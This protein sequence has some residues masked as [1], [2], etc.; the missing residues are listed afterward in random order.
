MRRPAARSIWPGAVVGRRDLDHVEAAEAHARQRADAAR[1]PRAAAGPRPPACPVAGRERRVDHVDVEAEER[2]RLADARRAR[3]ARSRPAP[4][5][6]SSSPPIDL[7]AHLARVAEVG[8]RVERPAHAGQ[9]R[10]LRARAAP[11]RPPAGTACR[12]SSARRS[13]GPRCRRARRAA[14]APSGPCRAA[15]AR[16]SPSTIEWSPPSTIGD[17]AGRDAAAPRP[18]GDLARGPLGVAG[19]DVEVA[20]G[21]RPTAPRTRRRRAP[22]GTGRSSDRRRRG[23]PPG[24]KRAPGPVAR[25]GVERDADDADVDAR[26]V[27]RRAG[28]GRTCGCPCSGAP[29]RRRAGRSAAA[30]RVT[31]PPRAPC[32]ACGRSRRA[33][34]PPCASDRLDVLERLRREPLARQHVRDARRVRGERLGRDPPDRLARPAR[35]PGRRGRPRAA[36]SRASPQGGG[37]AKARVRSRVGSRP[38]CSTA[39][40]QR[41]DQ[42]L[43]LRG[44]RARPCRTRAT[45]TFS[46]ASSRLMSSLLAHAAARARSRVA[47][48][49][50]TSTASRSGS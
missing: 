27:R 5:A 31:R 8:G 2:R 40:A 6:R 43:G 44:A 37:G 30:Q 26:R 33:A 11:P 41:R 22:G 18:V 45:I 23:S 32:A 1:A 46:P 9:Q 42:P 3:A 12:G 34:L 10:A 14:P 21:R 48:V 29:A 4:C 24:P 50:R 39:R 20:A 25:R 17:D 19:R 15:C 35:P 38:S 28:S 36:S 13:T 49:P 7:E 47:P 16:S